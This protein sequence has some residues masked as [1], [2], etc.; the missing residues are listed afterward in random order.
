MVRRKRRETRS[1]AEGRLLGSEPNQAL[2][3]S[4]MFRERT[5]LP[6]PF[7]SEGRLVTYSVEKL[8]VGGADFGKRSAIPSCIQVISVL[9]VG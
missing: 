4:R 9:S 7:V 8:D 2:S 5:P 6:T 3:G 1:Q